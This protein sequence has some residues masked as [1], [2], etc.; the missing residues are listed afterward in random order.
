MGIAASVIAFGSGLFGFASQSFPHQPP[1][2]VAS[3]S[4]VMASSTESMPPPPLPAGEVMGSSSP[5]DRGDASS[6][7]TVMRRHFFVDH[8]A[9]ST[10]QASSTPIRHPFMGSTT[11]PAMHDHMTQGMHM[12]STSDGNMRV[13]SMGSTSNTQITSPKN[14]WTKILN[15]F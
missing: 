15:L 14:I 9:S 2:F 12:S 13:M 10:E 5:S 11:P 8:Y 1:S 7:R 4:M 6:T 3:S